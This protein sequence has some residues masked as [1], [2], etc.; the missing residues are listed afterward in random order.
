[1]SPVTLLVWLYPPAVRERWGADISLEVSAAGLHS[2]PDTITGA[3]RI[4]LQPSIW[5]ESFVGQT[6]RVLTVAAFT[7]AAVTGLLLRSM[8]P[9]GALTA[10]IHHPATSLWL[11]PL[12]LGICLAAPLPSP[13]AEAL[14]RVVS[15]AVRTLVAPAVAVLAMVLTAWSG[16]ADH[17]AGPVRAALILYYWLTLGFVAFRLRTV[18][19]RTAC[20]ADTTI[21]PT[22]RRLRA[23]LLLM[24]SGLALAASQ[25]LVAL[26][27]AELHPD[28]LAPTLALALLAV[29]A[30]GT[31]QDLRHEGRA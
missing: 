13:R 20:T 18:V 7:F 27:R 17:P 30:I 21:V 11:G 19:A 5:P 26:A 2:W 1:M 25:S 9:S 31:A 4:W 6:R 15:V 22:M 8:A 10:D 23:A 12:L 14:H 29:T 16:V 28:S 3:V 24:G